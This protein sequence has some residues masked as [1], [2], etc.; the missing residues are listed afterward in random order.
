MPSFLTRYF[1]RRA[2]RSPRRERR[3]TRRPLLEQLEDRWQPS[4]ILA[5][6]SIQADVTSNQAAGN[7]GAVA[8][9]PGAMTGV[10]FV[11]LQSSDGNSWAN[12]YVIPDPNFGTAG[13]NPYD[14]VVDGVTKNFAVGIR[15]IAVDSIQIYKDASNSTLLGGVSYQNELIV[16]VVADQGYIQ[17]VNS[18]TGVLT[19]V[20]TGGAAALY[21]VPGQKEFDQMDPSTWGVFTVDNNG[22]PSAANTPIAVLPLAPQEDVLDGLKGNAV[23]TLYTG[24]QATALN[25]NVGQINPNGNGNDTTYGNFL[26]YQAGDPGVPIPTSTNQFHLTTPLSATVKTAG[27]QPVNNGEFVD[28]PNVTP[29]PDPEFFFAQVVNHNNTFPKDVDS[30]TLDSFNAIAGEFGLSNL[31]APDTGYAGT[32]GTA[33]ATSVDQSTTADQSATS[34]AP[35]GVVT[36]PGAVDIGTNF[37]GVESNTGPTNP[38]REIRPGYESGTKGTPTL[39]TTSSVNGTATNSYQL[40]TSAVTLTDSATLSGGNSSINSPITGSIT[41]TLLYSTDGITFTPVAGYTPE[42]VPV[43]GDNTYATPAGYTLPASGSTVVGTYQW[44]ATF[45][46]TDGGNNNASDVGN[47]NEQVAVSPASPTFTTSQTPTTATEGSI[48]VSD[49]AT[50]SG[51]YPFTGLGTISFTLEDSGN[52]AVSGYTTQ[53]FN[54]TANTTYSTTP[55]SMTLQEGTYHWAVSFTGDG[56]NNGYSLST[57]TLTVSDAPPTITGG[58]N[59]HFCQGDN[60]SSETGTFS[61][62]DDPVTISVSGGGTVS[63]TGTGVGAPGTWTWDGSG[64][65]AGDYTITVTATNAD[66]SVAAT[67]VTFTVDVDSVS[68]G[69][70][71]ATVN[72]AENATTSNTGTFSSDDAVTVTTTGANAGLGTVSFDNGTGKW[73]WTQTAAAGEGDYVVT[74]QASIAEGCSNTTQF[75]VHV[76]DVPPTISSSNV[77]VCEGDTA[78]NSGRF[79][80]FDDAVTVTEQAGDVGSVTQTGTGV[81]AAGTWKWSSG[82]G[83]AAGTYTVHLIATNAD[84]SKAYTSFTVQV[85]NDL[86]AVTSVKA[87]PTTT[88]VKGSPATFTISGSWADPG[89]GLT[90]GETYT[91]VTN[92]ATINWGD[93]GT[94]TVTL[95]INTT[96]HTYSVTAT[97]TY[98]ASGPFTITVTGGISDG[99][100]QDANCS[101]PS[102][103]SATVVVT[104]TSVG[105]P[106]T[107]G[108][109]GNTNGQAVLQK[110]DPAWR[111]LL[112]SLNLRNPNGTLFTVSTTGRSSTAYGQ[113]KTWIGYTSNNMAYLLSIQ[114]VTMEFNV[115]YEGVSASQHLYLGAG[116]PINTSAAS[117]YNPFW[118]NTGTSGISESNTL[119][120]NINN[121]ASTFGQTGTGTGVYA[122]SITIAQVEQDAVNML[123]T[124]N[125]LTSDNGAGGSGATSGNAYVFERALQSLLA[126]ANNNVAIFF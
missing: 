59:S 107:I 11:K 8:G 74:I 45:T 25:V 114:L 42:V 124:W 109:W 116:S 80:D 76:T 15:E 115:A 111:T 83:H 17:S 28:F 68:V 96:N 1:N 3:H 51:G 90:P 58:T 31:G 123:A 118:N 73:T 91:A 81:G 72:V 84:G 49:S 46:D 19:G 62:F 98:T 117:G 26:F 71:H 53:T 125:L 20:F 30:T 108:F 14:V 70:D 24:V 21:E 67:P 56:N 88:V 102:S 44:N 35:Q 12:N 120:A 65:P 48:S 75:T 57:E 60:T 79:S 104:T 112:N 40:G 95:T 77:H 29:S 82:S 13:Q 119:E 86:P 36:A 9:T 27:N 16:T 64:L 6:A 39:T 69:A 78:T 110:N 106:K 7:P 38:L 122:D 87:T 93:S 52:N 50:I 33:F 103:G 85:G 101:N 18:T 63:Q 37:N 94:S 23:V 55:V 66:N 54:V 121:G 97:H 34:Y 10:A 5:P 47:T 43:S 105:T 41:F 92:G 4:V 22:E 99:G 126:T 89:I 61:D 2:L 113:L 100:T 32:F